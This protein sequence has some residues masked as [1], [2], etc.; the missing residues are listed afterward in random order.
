MAHGFYDPKKRKRITAI[1]ALILVL[2]LVV[3]SVLSVLIR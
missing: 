2:A 1:I 3:P